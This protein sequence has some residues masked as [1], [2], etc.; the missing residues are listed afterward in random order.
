MKNKLTDKFIT[1]EEIRELLPNEPVIVEAGAHIGRD[2]VKMSKRWPEAKI[3]AFEP[4]VYL[5]N[6]L[7]ENTKKYPNI[8]CYNLALSHKVGKEIIYVSSDRSNAASSLL[9]PKEFLK[10]S[11]KVAFNNSIEIETITLDQ[12]AKENNIKK[13]DFLW[14]DMQGYEYFALKSS[15][16]ILKTITVIYTE[17]NITQ[18]YEKHPL[19]KEYKNWLE[20]QGFS[21]IKYELNR[22]TWGNALFAKI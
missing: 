17:I 9:K 11:P 3:F 19:F 10:E 8:I 16:N 20:S 7:I 6:Q 13:I 21:L 22:K 5:Y 1:K 15:P 2:T 4:I 18:R 12:W 14:L